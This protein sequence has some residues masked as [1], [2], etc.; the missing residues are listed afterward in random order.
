MEENCMEQNLVKL[1]EV[2]KEIYEKRRTVRYD[3][4]E[5]IIETVCKNTMRH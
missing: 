1:S 5:M 4:R 3:L 2:E